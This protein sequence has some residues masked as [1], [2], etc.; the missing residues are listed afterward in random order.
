MAK[1]VMQFLFGVGHKYAIPEATWRYYK[2]KK[3]DPVA[4]FNVLERFE[5]NAKF[6][7]GYA[8]LMVILLW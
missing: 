2:S 8:H 3:L 7:E 6:Q 1:C 4:I 5:Q